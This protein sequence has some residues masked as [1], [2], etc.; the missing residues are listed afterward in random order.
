MERLG[1]E[2]AKKPWHRVRLWKIKLNTFERRRKSWRKRKI[3]T[4]VRVEVW[5]FYSYCHSQYEIK[6]NK[7]SFLSLSPREFFSRFSRYIF[8]LPS[9]I[10]QMFIFH[11]VRSRG[12][13]ESH[14]RS[15]S[16]F[17]T[18][19]IHPTRLTAIKQ[20][21][22]LKLH[23]RTKVGYVETK[24]FY[25]FS[26]DISFLCCPTIFMLLSFS[27]KWSFR[28]RKHLIVVIKSWNLVSSQFQFFHFF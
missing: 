27:R 15:E 10:F 8:F 12:N 23:Q 5:S 2:K 4:R 24:I 14:E 1:E 26:V 17:G 20:G 22:K 13:V 3:F 18:W 16:H 21:Q 9:F 7:F 6:W 11:D 25:N 19:S 28:R